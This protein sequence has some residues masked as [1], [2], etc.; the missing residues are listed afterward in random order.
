MTI[1]APTHVPRG[2]NSRPVR[3]DSTLA[4]VLVVEDEE[5][6]SDALSFML[7]REGYEV[8]VAADGAIEQVDSLRSAYPGAVATGM[9]VF[10]HDLDSV[11]THPGIRARQLGLAAL[12]QEITFLA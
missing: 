8:V 4:R 2:G 10:T 6:F 11:L 9:S 7:R 3:K 5:S 12:G 1:V